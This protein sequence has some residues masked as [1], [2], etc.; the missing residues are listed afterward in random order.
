MWR[1]GA[2]CSLFWLL[3]PCLLNLPI[4]SATICSDLVHDLDDRFA[5][6]SENA[7]TSSE[8][9][10]FRSTTTLDRPATTEIPSTAF[11]EIS[12]TPSLGGPLSLTPP[13]IIASSVPSTTSASSPVAA[14]SVKS[15]QLVAAVL[16]GTATAIAWPLL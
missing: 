2:I 4:I 1:Q 6:H 16:F 8:H 9:P 7:S 5:P 12:S 15:L 3:I 11:R 10:A 14:P 13:S